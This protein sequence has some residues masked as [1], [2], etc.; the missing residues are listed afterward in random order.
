MMI[1][2][3]LK[4]DSLARGPTP[5]A[6]A[7]VGVAGAG[8]RVTGG[9]TLVE[10]LVVIAIVSLLLGMLLPALAAARRQARIAQCMTNLRQVGIAFHS[11]VADN[12][13][14]FPFYEEILHNLQW[15]YGG[16]HP[17]MAPPTFQFNSRPLNPY[18]GQS[19]VNT[20]ASDV[21]RCPDETG[22]WSVI[23]QP[24]GT[25]GHTSFQWHG[26]SYMAN[27]NLLRRSIP[28]TTEYSPRRL[29]EVRINHSR[30]ILAGDAQWFYDSGFGPWRA[31]AHG[32]Q[33]I[34]NI[35]FVDGSVRATEMQR[36]QRHTAR[37]TV[38][39]TPPPP[40]NDD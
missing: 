4:G 15:Y 9:F 5:A 23:G 2:R 17:S 36:G 10:L 35:V 31:D 8:A 29:S 27:F 19:P 38:L 22:V 26:N 40:E 34:A 33:Q 14:R 16:K 37:Y 28:N 7:R 24:G 39:V 3:R 1:M 11:Y 20:E 32:R 18:V 12:Q 6:G 30:V 21:F 13:D 25:H